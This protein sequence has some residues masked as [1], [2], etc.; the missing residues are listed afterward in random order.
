MKI[1]IFGGTFNPIHYGHLRVAGE[2][3]EMFSF[4]RFFF[5]PAG[6][7]PFQKPSL[8]DA[9]H[10][11]EMARLAVRG[12]RYFKVSDIEIKKRGPSFSVET[13]SRLKGRY[14]DGEFYFIIGIDAFL[15]LPKWKQPM[16]LMELTHFVIVSRPGF[17]FSDISSSRY[18]PNTG[19]K[20]LKKFDNARTV[21]LA[22][23]LKTGNKSFLCKTTGF[24]ISASRI[25]SLVQKRKNIKYLLPESV[26]S[27]I[28]SHKLYRN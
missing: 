17:C 1:G 28:I 26:E 21:R 13:I 25:R 5:I 8:A 15:D 12:N 9:Y 2:V 22:V 23:R 6:S 14:K 4:D 3:Q 18:F 7:P 20:Y 11:Y 10:R 19:R 16:R 27:Y 24:D